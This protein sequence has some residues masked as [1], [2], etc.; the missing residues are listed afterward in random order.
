MDKDKRRGSGEGGIY[1]RKDRDCYAGTV[2]LGVVNGKRVRKT[3]FGKTKRE[4]LDK[5]SA[6][7][8]QVRKGQITVGKDQ[9]VGEWLNTWHSG[10]EA[11]GKLKASTIRNYREIIDHYITDEVKRTKLVKLTAEHVDRMTVELAARTNRRTGQPLGPHD[12]ASCYRTGSASRLRITERGSPH[13]RRSRKGQG[14]RTFD[15]RAG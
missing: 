11:T 1:Y 5:L 3:V 4:V 6:L 15:A 14:K 10:L 9:T 7:Q 8:D 2:D 13:G 12:P